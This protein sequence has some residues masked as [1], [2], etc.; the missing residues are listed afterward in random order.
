MI[1]KHMMGEAILKAVSKENL[2]ISEIALY[3]SLGCMY[4]D[5]KPNVCR[6]SQDALVKPNCTVDILV[7]FSSCILTG[8]RQ[9]KSA[10]IFEASR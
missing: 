2:D 3:I 6:I 4:V 8:D 1:P 9:G 7:L 10:A 5:T